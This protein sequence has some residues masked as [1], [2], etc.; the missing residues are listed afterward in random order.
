MKTK[1]KFIQDFSNSYDAMKYLRHGGKFQFGDE[2]FGRSTRYIAILMDEALVILKILQTEAQN[3]SKS[4][5]EFDLHY[6]K[7][8]CLSDGEKIEVLLKSIRAF[9]L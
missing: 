8:L 3:E 1:L 5:T 6:A 2:T 4:K 7:I 9:I